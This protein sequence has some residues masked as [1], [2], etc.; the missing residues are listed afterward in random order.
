MAKKIGYISQDIYLLDASIKR[1]VAFGVLDKEIDDSKVNSCIRL[2]QLDDLIQNL[3]LG[4]NTMVGD[5]GVRISG[6]QKQRIGIA[7]ALYRK[8]EVLVLD[9]ATSSLDFNTEKKLIK[10]IE[11]LRGKYTI[12]TITHRLEAI[13]NCDEAFLLSDGKLVDRGTVDHLILKNKEL[14]N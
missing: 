8:S 11:R 10:D 1:N 13:K 3:P 7:R 6:G 2:A 9:E 5:R 4:F 14:I 12:I